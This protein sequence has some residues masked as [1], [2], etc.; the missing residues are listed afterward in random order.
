MGRKGGVGGRASCREGSRAGKQRQ[1]VLLRGSGRV[2]DEPLQGTGEWTAV[3]RPGK[4]W[5]GKKLQAG[6]PR[7]SEEARTGLLA[8]GRA[9]LERTRLE[10]RCLLSGG[11]TGRDAGG[12]RRWVGWW[13]LTPGSGWSSCRRPL[14]CAGGARRRK[15]GVRTVA[16]GTVRR[17]IQGRFPRYCTVQRESDAIYL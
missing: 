6:S 12:G 14:R 4:E 16:Y 7:E 17:T 13:I 15:R 9:G 2:G 10:G 3:G 11:A 1:T 8:D 5:G